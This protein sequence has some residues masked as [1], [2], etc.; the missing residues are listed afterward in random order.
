MKQAV[1]FDIDGTIWDQDMQIP[2]STR[3]A[4]RALKENGILTFLCSGRCRAAIQAEE[5]LALGFDG[6]V[7]GCG[8][9]IEYQGKE[10]WQQL[11]G[12]EEIHDIVN[13]LKEC[14]MP[15]IL[16]GPE[17]L[18]ADSREFTDDPFVIYL[19]NMLGSRFKAYEE[20]DLTCRASKMSAD[21]TA[22]DVALLKEKL[23]SNYDLIFHEEQ[24]V[25]IVPKGVSKATGIAR[26]CEMY[27]IR[28]EDTYA[29][30]DSANDLEML[31]YV[32]HGIAMG[33]GYGEV[34]R[35]ADYVTS[36]IHEDGIWNGLKH[37]G[38]I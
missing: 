14:H 11:L 34:K 23:G 3:K 33:N 9:Y 30:G 38:L 5:L 31:N 16:E 32:A 13:I 20:T 35:K 22:G 28:Q 4:V 10:V 24:A 37:Y 25:E 12:L 21:Y 18:Y 6:I 17:Y 2:Q 29:F 7:A 19:R 15:V 8:T 1:Y 36:D 26:T 27:G